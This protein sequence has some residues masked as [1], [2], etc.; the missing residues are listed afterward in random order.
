MPYSNESLLK[1]TEDLSAKLAAPGGGAAAALVGAVA[2]SLNCMVGNFTAG[3][4][5]YVSVSE[6]VKELLELSGKHRKEL[7]VLL[8]ADVEA[9]G[10]YS[11]ASKLSKNTVEEKLLRAKAM[12]AA[13]KTAA[14]VPFNIMRLCDKVLKVCEVL[15]FKGNKNLITD[16]GVSVCFA[17]AAQKSA[18]LNVLINILCLKDEAFKSKMKKES[19]S[20]LTEAERIE[21]LVEK[22]CFKILN[23]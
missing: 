23:G 7:L 2:A 17:K 4:E 1:F 9:Y 19:D 5:K 3:N 13:I 22:E 8:D 12:E 15:V 16:V 10:N 11:K 21:K 18:Y 6:E 20:L 14:E